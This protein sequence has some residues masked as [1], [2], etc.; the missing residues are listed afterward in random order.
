MPFSPPAAYKGPA[1]CQL[2]MC[3][4]MH[5]VEVLVSSVRPIP[6]AAL[7]SPCPRPSLR[8]LWTSSDETWYSTYSSHTCPAPAAHR[9]WS[10]SSPSS[11]QQN[12]H[13]HDTH[14]QE[15]LVRD[16]PSAMHWEKHVGHVHPSRRTHARQRRPSP[17]SPWSRAPHTTCVH[18]SRRLS[19]QLPRRALPLDD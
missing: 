7:A 5:D 19:M 18:T 6:L 4:R 16:E 9:S 1:H 3:T 10:P 13:K 12:L 2:C 15:D 14:G 17:R 8:S 11:S